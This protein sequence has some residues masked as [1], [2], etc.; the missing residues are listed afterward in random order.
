MLA[1]LFAV[2]LFGIFFLRHDPLSGEETRLTMAD[3]GQGDGFLLETENAAVLIDGGSTDRDDTGDVLANTMLYYGRSRID[4]IFLSHDD[5]DHTSGVISLLQSGQVSVGRIYLPDTKK[6]TTEFSEVR[7]AAE[8]AGIPVLYL[9]AGDRITL[10]RLT[11]EVLWPGP[12]AEES[13]NDT[14]MV[15]SVH[16]PET[17]LLFTGDISSSSEAAIGSLKAHDFLKVPHHGSAYS[18]SSAFL[19]RVSPRFSLVSYGKYNTYGHPSLET[20]TRLEEA[21][22]RAFLSG[23]DGAVSFRIAPDGENVTFASR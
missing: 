3:V 5:E 18:S 9:S 8:A 6:K 20:L 23:R 10:D 1:S 12:S 11:F 17:S 16:S 22:S 7:K 21:K 15:L 2:F 14:S 13:G 19:K 4:A